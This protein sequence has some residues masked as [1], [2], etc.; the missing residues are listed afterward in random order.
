M[1]EHKESTVSSEKFPTPPSTAS[2]HQDVKREASPAPSSSSLSS[3]ATSTLQAIPHAGLSAQPPQKRRKLT[4]VEKD[5]QRAQKEQRM[6]EKEEQRVKREEEKQAKDE[7]KRRKKE[8]KE[9][10]DREKELEKQRREHEKQKKEE[11]KI[12]E[13]EKKERAQPKLASFF[14][15]PKTP[16][17]GS[18]SP[19]R[20][21]GDHDMGRR[22]SLSVEP[23]EQP[24]ALAQPTPKSRHQSDYERKFL[25][26]QLP[27]HTTLAPFLNE[28]A[29]TDDLVE[30]ILNSGVA[31]DKP[32]PASSFFTDRKSFSRGLWQ[33]NARE[34]MDSLNGSAA[35]PVDLTDESG[36]TYR[37]EDLLGSVTIR[38]LHFAE[39][40]RPP[41]SG[42]YTK[43]LSPRITAKLR[44][45]PFS[46]IRQDTNY[47]YDSE[48]EWDEPEEGE[49]ILSDGEDDE[50]SIGAPDEMEDF[51]DE[52]EG[53]PR[54]RL[55]TGD[56]KPVITGL[57]WDPSSTGSNQESP[58]DL[59]SMKL[60]FFLDLTRPSIDPFSTAY[61][62]KE[63]AR[64]PVSANQVLSD[65]KP[66]VMQLEKG[67][68][69]SPR[70]PLQ[71]RLSINGAGI[72]GASSGTKGPIMIDKSVKVVK[73]AA[74]PLDGEDL[75][76]FREA[77]V[78][79]NVPKTELLKALK[80]RFP[81]I[82][83][84]TIKSTLN[85]RFEFSGTS[86]AEKT[87]T[88]AG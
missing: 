7:E 67:K 86:R 72:L 25:P 1:D 33:P 42:S 17:I 85:D 36:Q 18:H 87:W 55:I 23:G 31:L 49:D 46:K 79:S 24:V 28:P 38:H 57:C 88:F 77:V 50:E 60:E 61:W 45:K 34:V 4:V 64:A 43:S 71:P 10:K 35:Q 58:V 81:K 26:F 30:R 39:D 74:K 41:Y 66:P 11:E 19:S 70:P 2:P 5:R 82:T 73:P 63:G 68:I 32:A 13:K 14:M 65:S 53:G 75:N 8:E 62:P 84:D 21:M 52:D 15:K 59:D 3:V 27:S 56:L 29:A 20:S 51:L 9:I 40:V 47:D 83:N 22:K 76:E 37:P 48:A 78:G 6:R 69:A 16:I 54:R 12:R 44:R 80:K